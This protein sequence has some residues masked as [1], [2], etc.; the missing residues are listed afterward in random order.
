MSVN[1]RIRALKE[2][3]KNLEIAL[4]QELKSM[5]SNE[6]YVGALK[7]QKLKIRDEIQRLSRDS[8]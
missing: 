3:H 5:K 8:G 1:D 2:K 4:E 7:A 6:G